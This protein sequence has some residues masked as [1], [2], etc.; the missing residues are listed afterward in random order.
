M[1][2]GT[3]GLDIGT[4]AV[5]AA[6][7]RG[8]DPG[9]LVRFAQLSLPG[10]AM[11]AGEIAD[12][13]VVSRVIA[14]LWR[15]G[16]FKGK[17]VSV[18]VS[19]QNVVVR[20][21]EVPK[22]DEADLRG[23][24]QYQVSDYIP[25]PIE[26]AILD[27]VVLD[28]FVSDDG[29]P[30]MRLLTVAALRSM[31]DRV[32][33]TVRHAGLDPIG[34]DLAPLAAVRALTGAGDPVVG[35]P[36]AEAVVDVGAGVTGIVVHVAGS[37]RFVRILPAGGGDITQALVTSLGVPPEEAEAEKAAIGLMAEGTPVAAGA[38]RVIEERARGFID[39]V[40]RSIDF[41]Q[42]QQDAI[43]LERIVIT[44]GGARLPGFDERLSSALGLPV[45]HGRALARVEVGDIGL[46]FEQIEQVSAVAAVAI[47]LAMED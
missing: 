23:A 15:R 14:D 5:R 17:R 22:M 36:Q 1:A 7:V 40:R 35:E 8:R 39:D 42:S 30:M 43:R 28:E 19:N 33:D 29:A 24:L 16:D 41:Y 11:V 37:P 44:G 4:S 10:G 6:E 27:F 18:A 2:K 3:I 34:I 12:V 45:E 32:V 9:T 26:E 25:M 46:T 47:G 20:Q 21:V 31:I 38:A 13:E